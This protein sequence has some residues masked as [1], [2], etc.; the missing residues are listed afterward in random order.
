[1]LCNVQFH[2]CLY[3]EWRMIFAD[4]SGIKYN[5]LYKVLTFEFLS[6]AVYV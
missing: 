2:R 3:Y 4:P 6:P 5:H 1:M